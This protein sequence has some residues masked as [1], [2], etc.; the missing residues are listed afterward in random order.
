MLEV[1]I[2]PQGAI[3]MSRSAT[4]PALERPFRILLRDGVAPIAEVI[5][6]CDSLKLSALGAENSI[7]EFIG[8]ALRRS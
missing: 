6:D 1:R 3:P 7:R 8:P 5:C 2:F 4:L